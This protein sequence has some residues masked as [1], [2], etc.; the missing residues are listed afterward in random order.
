MSWKSRYGKKNKKRGEGSIL[1]PL[2]DAGLANDAI[3][4]AS[5]RGQKMS[6]ALM[7]FIEP[8]P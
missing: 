1:K 2:R 7:E 4:V 3:V 8:Y 5:P 6:E